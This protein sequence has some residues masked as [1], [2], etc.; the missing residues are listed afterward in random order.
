M[1]SKNRKEAVRAVVH[2]KIVAKLGLLWRAAGHLVADGG[3]ERSGWI[4]LAIS[5]T[6]DGTAPAI[7]IKGRKDVHQSWHVPTILLD[8]TMQLDLV[9]PFWPT[10]DLRADIRLQ[11]PHQ[12]VV[13]IID[14]SHSKEQLRKS[15]GLRD[16]HAILCREARRYTPGRVL[17]VVQKEIEE[18]L[19]DLGP[20]PINL[21]LAHHN[22][23]AGHD[24]WGP[25]PGREG[26]VA[27]IVVG[28]TAPSPAAVEAMAEALI[29]AAI[30]P[31]KGWYPKVEAARE[32]SDGTFRP[33]ETDR[34]PH[35]IAE[36]I[37]WQIAEG[38]LVQIIGR[39]RGVNRSDANPVD[40]L[41]ATNAPIP[42]SIERL[43]SAA[44]LKPFPADLMMAAG[45]IAFENAA[46]AAVAYPD[47]WK[48]HEAA[49][50]AMQRHPEQRLGTNRNKEYSI[51]LTL[52]IFP[53]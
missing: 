33:A 22:A 12:H 19:A 50:K 39:P 14:R 51:T 31:I 44:D 8:A 1:P 41:L 23:I 47:L 38:E 52:A 29:G 48:T 36:A 34:H 7:Y 32:M 43:I 2:N 10:M 49:K 18:K 53:I 9:R 27:L 24:E 6:T 17:A 46:D 37:R 30:E 16:V 13:Q 4:S 15:A 5:K 26:V 35:P 21:E 42:V 28:R 11:T 20:L 3:P 45:G 40:V 25:G